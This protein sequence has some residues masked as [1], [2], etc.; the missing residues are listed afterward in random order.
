MTATLF[1][2]HFGEIGFGE[3]RFG[4]IRFG[5]IEVR[6]G[7]TRPS[8]AVYVRRRLLVSLVLCAAV[9]IIVGLSVHTVLADRG[10]VPASASTIR[11]ANPTSATFVTPSAMPVVPLAP[12]TISYI[13]Q[14]GDSLWSL[15]E[16]FH[17]SHSVG[18]YVETLVEANGGS[19]VQP[20]QVLVMP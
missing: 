2:S 10:G 14:P 11:S 3:I 7:A 8:H 15:A 20:G 17:A 13:V 1:P 16:R 5:E 18:S 12:A 4:E 6:F 9:A 19:V